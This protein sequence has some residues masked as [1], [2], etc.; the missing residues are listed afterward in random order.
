MEGGE[1]AEEVVFLRFG[2]RRGRKVHVGEHIIVIGKRVFRYD[3]E[4]RKSI[5]EPPLGA[6]DW[7]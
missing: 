1:C 5:G 7:V 3:Y 4:E 6:T 2:P